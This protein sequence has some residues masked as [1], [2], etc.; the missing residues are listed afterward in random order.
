MLCDAIGTWLVLRCCKKHAIAI[1][2]H[3]SYD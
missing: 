3:G 2:R 1:S